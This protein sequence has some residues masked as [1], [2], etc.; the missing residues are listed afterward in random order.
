MV[1]GLAYGLDVAD[2]VPI[3]LLPTVNLFDTDGDGENTRR[4]T[5]NDV[6]NC[7][8]C[9]D[10]VPL[11]VPRADDFGVPTMAEFF[12]AVLNKFLER[13]TVVAGDAVGVWN[14]SG[15]LKSI[16]NTDDDCCLA[17]DGV[18]GGSTEP[19]HSD[20]FW[21]SFWSIVRNAVLVGVE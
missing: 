21:M 4:D 3:A 10:F 11:T 20:D 6:F 18:F 19:Y 16:R 7:G 8:F 14:T 1:R 2:L 15:D 13:F 5:F 12:R 17:E 9:A